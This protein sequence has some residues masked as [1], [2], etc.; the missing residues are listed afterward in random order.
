MWPVPNT[1]TWWLE[2]SYLIQVILHGCARQQ[3]PPATLQ[4]VQ[5]TISQR[6]IILEPVC[7]I[8]DE[9]VTCA[10]ASKLVCMQPEGLITD[11]EAVVGV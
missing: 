11:N 3:H 10:L 5:G 6:G 4:R 7:F 1:L 9:Q 2:S 8:T